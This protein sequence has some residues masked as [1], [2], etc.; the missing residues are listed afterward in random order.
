MHQ[1][2]DLKPTKMRLI[3]ALLSLWA[4]APADSISVR[5]LVQHAGA[6]Q[7][8]IHY[9]FGDIERLYVEASAVALTAAEAWMESRLTALG[10]LAGGAVAP[11]LQASLI[12]STIADWTGRE[13]R[14]AM[15]ARFAPSPEW[16]SA[17]EEF[18]TRLAA[19]IGLGDHAVAL[20]AFAAGE[21]ARHLLVWNPPLDRALLEETI[22]ALV[23]WLTERRFAPDPVR[24]SHQ[25]LAREGY[26]RPAA[27]HDDALAT[28]IQ[29]VAA[30][31]LAQQGHAGVTF[32][33]VA[34]RAG[35]TLGKVI[36]SCGTKS[37]LLRGALHHLYEREALG[38]DR[39]GFE[40]QRLP[41]EV[42]LALLL[43]AVLSGQQPVLRAYDEIE[44]AICNGTEH[45]DLRGVVRSM[46]DPSG[47][48]ALKQM[49]GGEVP[50]A[51]LVAAFSATIRGIAS[52]VIYGGYSKDD[53][54]S[55][56]LLAL[57]PFTS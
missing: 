14:L 51:A 37:E 9:H 57:Q 1:G 7:A 49:L 19:G 55:Y 13:R 38:G 5:T 6:A 21:N 2:N 23:L 24:A 15:A 22:T 46:E 35:V 10:G 29:E 39:A 18:W 42:V 8:A 50:P 56:A 44:R 28:T 4:D 31:L 20:A 52:R 27:R 25:R 47:T 48:W 54:R 34:A 17:W 53:L 11:A 43:E 41:P 40:A 36:Y 32:R 45:A 30:D 16:Q 26:D 12:A 3:D 33:A